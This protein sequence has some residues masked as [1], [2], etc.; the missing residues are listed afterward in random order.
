TSLFSSIH[1]RDTLTHHPLNA[2]F[3]LVGHALL[4][5]RHDSL[6]MMRLTATLFGLLTLSVFY[7]LTRHWYGER[8]AVLGT[9]LFGTSAWFLHT[10]R[11]GTPDVL[12]FGLL[13]LTACG[14]WLKHST[15][16]L[17]VILALVLA[18]V[19]LYIPGMMW[20]IGAGV[21]WQ[22]KTIDR[23]FKKHLWMVTLGGF[24]VLAALAPLA[25]ALYHDPAFAKELAG[26]PAVGWPQPFTVIRNL[27]DVPVQLLWRGPL[28]PE[29]WLG[30]L[31]V[32][33]A[34]CIGAL[35]LGVYVHAKHLRLARTQLLLILLLAGAALVAL[36]GGVSLSV[37][38]P[39]IF[40]LV[41][42]GAGFLLDRWYV[43]FPRNTIA[44]GVGLGLVSLAVLASAWYGFRHYFVAWP[45]APETKSTFLVQL[46]PSDT[47]H[48]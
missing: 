40:I 34:L 6:L 27:L 26:L 3:I 16:P 31:A 47:I 14:V 42:A 45:E 21:V 30:E 20:F 29:H 7:W 32:L 12:L 43:V 38:V 19:F 39:F 25:W 44:Q 24:L 18:A 8:T 48:K 5:V 17:P 28:W 33:N 41:A 37:V 46:A 1:W 23:A 4:L 10:A 11:L 2:P 9:V 13:C 15:K 36:G 35:F 22:W